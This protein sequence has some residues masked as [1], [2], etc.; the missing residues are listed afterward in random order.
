MITFKDEHKL[1]FTF[2]LQL[3]PDWFLLTALGSVCGAFVR[4]QIRSARTKK[5][6]RYYFVAIIAGI[7]LFLFYYYLPSNQGARITVDR[8]SAFLLGLA[9][10]Y[11]GPMTV[12]K[13]SKFLLASPHRRTVTK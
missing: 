9:G 12:D 3:Q 4:L 5:L 13:I 8:G 2:Y 6:L 10:G 1:P 11:L 7:R